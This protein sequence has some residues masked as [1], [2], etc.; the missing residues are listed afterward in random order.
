MVDEIRKQKIKKSGYRRFSSVILP[1]GRSIDFSRKELLVDMQEWKGELR[2]RQAQEGDVEKL[3]RLYES[4]WGNGIRISRD[5]MLGQIRNFPEG[6]IV[7]CMEGGFNPVSMIN[8]MLSIFDPAKGAPVGYDNATGNK[9]FST[10]IPPENLFALVNGRRERVLPVAYCVSIAVPSELKKSGFA[11]ETL[12]YARL[13]S[14]MNGLVP[15][16]YSAPRGFGS[17]LEANP[18]LEIVDYLHMTRPTRSGFSAYLM[19][20]RNRIPKVQDAFL[21]RKSGKPMRR[22]DLHEDIFESYNDIAKDNPLMGRQDTAFWRFKKN[23]ARKFEDLYGR[24]MEI[25]DFCVL[26]GRSLLDPVIGMHMSNGARFLREQS[27]RI[28]HIFPNS[29]PEDYKAAGYNIVVTYTYH[30]LYGH[31]FMRDVYS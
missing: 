23:D 18:S 27:G 2:F 13:F 29:R 15:M 3:L 8:I 12:N 31:E 20:M 4:A 26:T 24:S 25:E 22:V 5:Q 7:G 14:I 1:P 21:I 19:K 28:S 30:T 9:T 17:A 6:Q 10:S 11:Y 16:P